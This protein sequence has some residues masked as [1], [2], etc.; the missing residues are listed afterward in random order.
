MCL[1]VGAK[2][3]RLSFEAEMPVG[4]WRAVCGGCGVLHH[5]HRRPKRMVGLWCC[6]CGPERGRLLWQL[7]QGGEH[8]HVA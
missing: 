5:K 8:E 2:P 3:E 7:A 1:R 4:R 6:R